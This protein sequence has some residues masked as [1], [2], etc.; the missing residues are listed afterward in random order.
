MAIDYNALAIPK[1]RTKKQ[2]KARKDREDAKQLKAFR[3]AVWHREEL[4]QAYVGSTYQWALCQYCY[5]VVRRGHGVFLTGEV[6]H[7]I[8]R[9]HKA[10]RYDP[11]NGVLLCNHLV[12]NCHE[13]A[14]RGLI[15]V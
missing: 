6:H 14:E 13:K 11:D 4:K 9:R 7:R 15:T 3:D 5:E 10:T 12:N 1:G 8:S 2:V